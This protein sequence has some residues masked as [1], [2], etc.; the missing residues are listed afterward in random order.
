MKKPYAIYPVLISSDLYNRVK[1]IA[2]NKSMPIIG[3]IADELQKEVDRLESVRF[4][5]MS[6]RRDRH[7]IRIDKD[8]YN[9]LVDVAKDTD[10]DV[11]KIIR[12][13]IRRIVRNER[14]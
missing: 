7:S 12:R 11:G 13:C 5:D 8:L 4:E 3:L 14:C 9:R 6:K 2:S 10:S 1:R